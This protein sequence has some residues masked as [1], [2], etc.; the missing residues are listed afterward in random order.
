MTMVIRKVILALLL[1]SELASELSPPVQ[2][3]AD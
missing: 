2:V 1:V 3:S